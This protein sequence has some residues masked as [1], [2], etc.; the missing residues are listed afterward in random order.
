MTPFESAR[1]VVI[2]F[3]LALFVWAGCSE[4]A[5]KEPPAIATFRAQLMKEAVE[6]KLDVS[7]CEVVFVETVPEG[8]IATSKCE[9]LPYE[10]AWLV[11]DKYGVG[12]LLGCRKNPAYRRIDNRVDNT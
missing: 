1:A 5:T 12:Q 8:H 10:C 11:D 3:V 7:K 2:G 4:A 6:Y 9:E